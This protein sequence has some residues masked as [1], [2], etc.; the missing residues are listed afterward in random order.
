MLCL[1]FLT[2]LWYST[3]LCLQLLARVSRKPS[4]NDNSDGL[5]PHNKDK[6]RY[7]GR[8]PCKPLPSPLFLLFLLFLSPAVLPLHVP[9][10]YTEHQSSLYK[11]PSVVIVLLYFHYYLTLDNMN[12]V[13]LRPTG[14]S[15]SEYIN[16]SFLDVSQFWTANCPIGHYACLFI[17]GLQ[18]EEYVHGSAGPCGLYSE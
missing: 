8:V 10:V 1:S 6:N 12:R 18:A 11:P 14:V 16:A 15:G 9:S 17:V 7:P 5:A 2:T 3:H 13:R 4:D